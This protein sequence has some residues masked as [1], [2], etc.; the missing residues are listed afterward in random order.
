MYVFYLRRNNLLK[1]ETIITANVKRKNR[2]ISSE[3]KLKR[4]MSRGAIARGALNWRTKTYASRDFGVG[5]SGSRLT[6]NL[7]VDGR[8]WVLFFIY[9][10]RRKKVTK[11][12]YIFRTSEKYYI[13]LRTCYNARCDTC[14]LCVSLTSITW[15]KSCHITHPIHPA[16]P[17]I[18]DHL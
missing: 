4:Q 12:S 3:T 18:I 7:Y 11:L 10:R 5:Y 17:Q 13:K 9:Q 16:Q 2:D 8:W 14:V 1:S 15:L 6:C